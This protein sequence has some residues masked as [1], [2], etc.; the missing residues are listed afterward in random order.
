[1]VGL[2]QATFAIRREPTNNMDVDSVEVLEGVPR[3]YRGTL[4]VV[5][6]YRSFLKRIGVTKI[7]AIG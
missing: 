1:V 3:G 4:V 5:S 2:A 7:V 6:H